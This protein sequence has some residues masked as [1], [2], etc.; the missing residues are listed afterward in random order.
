MTGNI[1]PLH[2]EAHQ[3][4]AALLPWYATGRLD[5]AD[6]A[7]VEA[8]LAAC[9]ECQADLR[10][11]RR[12]IVEVAAISVEAEPAWAAMKAKLEGRAAPASR[13]ERRPRRALAAGWRGLAFAAP[14][15]ALA[16]LVLLI[17]PLQQHQV[18]HAMGGAPV[19]AGA[20]LVVAFR[21]DVREADM[22][23]L[24]LGSDARL[25]DGPNAAGA[26]LLS[27]PMRE[28]GVV[29]SRLR[30]RPEVALAQPIDPGGSP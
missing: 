27:V 1:I 16:G 17:P 30:A 13:P 10:L 22:R 4:A 12:L 25:V 6:Q 24:L 18:Y 11:E 8:H 14:M 3:D 29:L 15:A 9:P 5:A 2:G 7:R 26:Y 20:D 19:A 28:R 21:P 23:R